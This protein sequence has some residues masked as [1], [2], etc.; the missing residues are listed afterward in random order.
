MVRVVWTDSARAD[1]RGIYDWISRDSVI[2][3]ER[4]ANRLLD[5]PNR[6]ELIP[7]S[8]SPVEEFPSSGLRELF[9]GDYR[10]VYLYRND[11]CR[12]VRVLHGSRD[13]KR[14][15]DPENLP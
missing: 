6:L 10:I 2:R 4:W 8:G 7:E 5:A 1:V 9:V 11:E 13:L 12:I 14:M 3:A 15:L